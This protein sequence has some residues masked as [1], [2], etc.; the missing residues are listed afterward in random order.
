LIPVGGFAQNPPQADNLKPQ[1]GKKEL[2]MFKLLKKVCLFLILIQVFIAGAYKIAPFIDPRLKVR[3]DQI[4]DM[5]F[6]SDDVRRIFFGLM[7]LLPLLYILFTI[8]A[9]RRH[10]SYTIRGKDGDSIISEMSIRK[11]LI[12]A[13]RTI[14]TVVKVKP[15]IKIS[16]G[17]LDVILITYIR[18]DQYMPNICERVRRRA[19]STLS[20]VLGIDRILPIDVKI[21]DVHFPHPPLAEKIR[22]RSQKSPQE[23]TPAQSITL[24]SEMPPEAMTPIHEEMPPEEFHPKK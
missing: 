4:R 10:A 12:S 18:L 6:F 11:S 20:E 5:I 8:R 2:N 22:A 15:I 1:S 19:H 3:R 24:T 7:L 9:K 16:G 21:Q 13:V 17:A 14:P 23:G